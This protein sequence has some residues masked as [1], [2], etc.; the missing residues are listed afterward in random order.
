M[1]VI[2]LD[3]D[4]VLVNDLYAKQHKADPYC[5]DAL[6]TITNVTGAK[7]VISSSWKYSYS[8]TKLTLMLKQWGVTGDIIGST[9]NV[10]NRPR[11]YEV[12]SWL[13]DYIEDV[14]VPVESFVVIDDDSSAC[15][16]SMW[17]VRTKFENGLTMQNADRAIGILSP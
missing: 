13:A 15:P 8:A 9:P 4:G 7:I 11:A 10:E 12:G 5:V 14:G 2:F 16:S 1:K 17:C 3:I 6:N